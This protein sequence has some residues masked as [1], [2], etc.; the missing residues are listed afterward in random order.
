M[1]YVMILL[2]LSTVAN[3]TMTAKE[4]RNRTEARQKRYDA[5]FVKKVDLFIEASTY[6]GDCTTFVSAYPVS[7]K[8]YDNEVQKLIELGYD[9]LNCPSCGCKGIEADINISWCEK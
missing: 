8:A 9:I 3:A 2:L 5:A 7:K 6:D 1:K 4:A